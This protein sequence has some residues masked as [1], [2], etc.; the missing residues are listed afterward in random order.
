MVAIP[1]TNSV[2]CKLCGFTSKLKSTTKRHVI[3]NHTNI[4]YPCQ[5]CPKMNPLDFA[6]LIPGTSNYACRICG[7]N[8]QRRKDVTKHAIAKHTNIRF[9]CQYCDKTWTAE[10]TR[11][12]HYKKVHKLEVTAPQIREMIELERNNY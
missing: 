7:Y 11:V 6:R 12:I 9:P 2:M 8:A 5:I 3:A 4:R 1:G 10:S